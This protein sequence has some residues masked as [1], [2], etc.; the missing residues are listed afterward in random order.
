M[1]RKPSPPIREQDVMARF[2]RL[3]ATMAPK[4]ETKRAAESKAGKRRGPKPR[5]PRN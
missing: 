5:K 2:D 4:V 3:L 1:K